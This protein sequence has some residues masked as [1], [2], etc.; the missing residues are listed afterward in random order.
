MKNTNQTIGAMNP[1]VSPEALDAIAEALQES[2]LTMADYARAT[3]DLY[4]C[5]IQGTGTS[6]AAAQLLLSAYNGSNWQL[7]ITDL[8]LL[9]G[10]LKKQALIFIECRLTLGEEPHRVL[11]SGD[12]KFFALARQWRRYHI[13]NRWKQICWECAGSGKAFVNPDDDNDDRTKTCPECGGEGL[14]AEVESF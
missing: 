9:H 14:L 3:E 10:N 1:E 11:G 7:D 13:R 6:R 4:H 12:K 2:R 5:A 8:C